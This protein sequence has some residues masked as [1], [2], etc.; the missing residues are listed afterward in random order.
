MSVVSRHYRVTESLRLNIE[1]KG[2]VVRSVA[3]V[4]STTVFVITIDELI[5]QCQLNL[6]QF[7]R[8]SS[9]WSQRSLVVPRPTLA[10]ADGQRFKSDIKC[11]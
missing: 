8:L 2:E 10:S 4:P 11:L 7:K 6:S 9:R 5:Y 1:L 3:L